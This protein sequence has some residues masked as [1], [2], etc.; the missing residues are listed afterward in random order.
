MTKPLDPRPGRSE[1][2]AGIRKRRPWQDKPADTG[3]PA[4]DAAPASRRPGRASAQPTAPRGPRAGAGAGRP[5]AGADAGDGHAAGGVPQKHH[6]SEEPVDPS[7]QW[8]TRA[9]VEHRTGLNGNVIYRKMRAGDFPEPFKVGSRSVRW[10]AREIEA[11][12][13]SRP[14]SHGDGIRRA[15]KRKDEAGN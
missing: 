11:W 12:K 15:R 8:I 5:D 4:V 2:R 6:G 10:S 14:R 7:D 9:E 1:D 3:A 13:K